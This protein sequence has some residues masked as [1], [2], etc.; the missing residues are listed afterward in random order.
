MLGTV[1]APQI[2]LEQQQIRDLIM[3]VNK[4]WMFDK[5]L[6]FGLNCHL[7]QL[8]LALKPQHLELAQNPYLQGVQSLPLNLKQSFVRTQLATHEFLYL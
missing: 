1:F 5:Q 6:L 7:A 2:A 3:N 8:L 4:S